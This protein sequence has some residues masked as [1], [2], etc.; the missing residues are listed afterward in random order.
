MQKYLKPFRLVI[1]TAMLAAIGFLFLDFSGIVPSAWYQGI[2][3]L[4]F[5]PSLIKFKES[6]VH[7]LAI[8]AYGFV[9]VLVLT[10]LFGRVYCSY[11]CPLGV[12]QDVVIWFSKKL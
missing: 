3:W 8:T 2:A 12:F 10:L 5:F 7:G 9:A 11:I 1:S 4:Q 6:I